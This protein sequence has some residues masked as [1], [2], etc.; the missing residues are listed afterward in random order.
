VNISGF[1]SKQAV[2]L[3][4]GDCRVSFW[5]C[6]CWS[7]RTSFPKLFSSGDHFYQ[8][9]CSTDPPTLVPFESKLFKI[10]KYSVWYA[11]HINFIFSVF[12]GLMFNLRGPQGQN[13][14][15]TYGPRTTVW[16]TLRLEYKV[17][18]CGNVKH[19][20]EN[21]CLHLQCS[22]GRFSKISLNTF[23]FIRRYNL[24]STPRENKN[25]IL[26]SILFA[27]FFW[28]YFKK[29]DIWIFF[30]NICYVMKVI[31]RIFHVPVFNL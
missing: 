12:F 7:S 20:S 26:A 28:I 23:A 14:R 25:K 21:W 15:T 24:Q 2:T 4:A 13:P 17:L 1:V 30:V 8:S 9:E 19:F 16:T 18:C 10:L 5:C 3:V 27:F 6:S 29:T 31:E 11:I 22:N